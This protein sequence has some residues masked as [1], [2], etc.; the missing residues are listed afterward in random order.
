MQ[1]AVC[2]VPVGALR[3]EPH[4]NAEMISQHLFGECCTILES[5]PGWIKIK[6]KYD[7][8]EGWCQASHLEEIDEDLFS[9]ANK[10]LTAGWVNEVSY[11]GKKMFIPF[12]SSLATFKKNKTRW[13]E[14]I[15]SHNTDTYNP[16][17]EKLNKKNIKWISAKF[18]NTAYLWGGKSVFGIDCSGF[19]QSVYKFL[20]IYLPR[21]S[22]QQA[23]S[24]N[25][26]EFLADVNCGDLCFFDNDE[27]RITHVGILLNDHQIIHSSGKVRIDEIDTKGIINS[28]SKLRTHKI[29]MI[30]R[31]F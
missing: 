5:I 28:D 15:I 23:E 8:Y 2:S 26:I 17:K 21:D 24:G 9:S 7:N 18:L 29:K 19:T 14:N 6:C 20:N 25:T 10:K 22:W 4:H 12:G 1:Y 11:N 30:K 3:K 13:Q 27:G 16:D 31:Y